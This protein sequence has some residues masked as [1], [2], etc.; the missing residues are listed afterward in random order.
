[1]KHFIYLDRYKM[2]SLSSQLMAGVTDYILKESRRSEEDSTEQK[3][4]FASGRVMAEIIETT[5]S[6]IEKKFLHDY[7]YSVF[8]DKLVAES[9]MFDLSFGD[10]ASEIKER[11]GNCKIVRIKARGMFVDSNEVVRSLRSFA[12]I[13]QS[14]GIIT[15][16]EQRQNLIAKILE[17]QNTPGSKKTDL[18]R[19]QGELK[20]L[21]SP[22][23][24]GDQ[25]GNDKLYHT[26]LAEVL[27]Y[28][29]KGS[30]DLSLVLG[31]LHVSG[32]LSRE[33]L[34][35]PIESIIKKY[36]RISEVEFTMIG[37][38]TQCGD[39]AADVGE[40]DYTTMRSGIRNSIAALSEFEGNFSGRLEEEIIVDPI[41]VYI[42]L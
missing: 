36:S 19:M 42:D 33:G 30:L 31:E 5:S 41:A 21:S 18:G 20:A 39:E 26:H 25:T 37:I 2:Y 34:R 4:E 8:E 6:N 24:H 3:G 27:E 23:S 16:N 32:E 22:N 12:S 9:K 14:F 38:V 40:L 10:T 28:C 15:T 1:M 13:M 29:F 11:I 17:V 35:E 7:A